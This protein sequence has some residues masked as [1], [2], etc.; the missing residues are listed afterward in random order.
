[1]RQLCDPLDQETAFR[2]VGVAGYRGVQVQ[3]RAAPRNRLASRDA[4]LRCIDEVYPMVT[5]TSFARLSITPWGSSEPALGPRSFGQTHL[6][7]DTGP[8]VREPQ[9]R[10]VEIIIR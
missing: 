8:G 3:L 4:W 2:P 9:N 5:H 1:M 6:L 10:R 7:V